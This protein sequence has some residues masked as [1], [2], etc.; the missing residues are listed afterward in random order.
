[1]AISEMQRVW[2]MLLLDGNCSDPTLTGAAKLR[3]LLDNLIHARKQLGEHEEAEARC[4]PE[5]YGFEEYI[6]VLERRVGERDVTIANQVAAINAMNV[7]SSATEQFTMGDAHPCDIS[8]SAREQTVEDCVA[9]LG[10]RVDSLVTMCDRAG[11]TREGSDLAQR[12]TATRDAI[13][14][15]R[16]IG[17]SDRGGVQK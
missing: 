15:I 8:R 7:A 2:D 3:R 1:M 17:S 10:E 6:G 5:D 16:R 12:V 9:A 11:Y 14:I 4:C 13:D